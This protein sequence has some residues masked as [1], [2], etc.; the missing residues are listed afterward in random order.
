MKPRMQAEDAAAAPDPPDRAP[1]PGDP[2][3]AEAAD[4]PFRAL[5]E[6]A[7]D[8]MCIF[9]DA[10]CI[11]DANPAAGRLYGVPAAQL[12]RHNL[13]ESLFSGSS[14][15]FHTIVERFKAEGRLRDTLQIR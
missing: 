1:V 4:G 10:G 2:A 11:L 15:A 3:P 13:R 5:F 8:A 7:L 14:A 9:D 12:R 6:T